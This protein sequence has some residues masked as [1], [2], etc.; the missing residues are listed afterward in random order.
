MQNNNNNN[1]FNLFINKSSFIK[2][3]FILN[4]WMVKFSFMIFSDIETLTNIFKQTSRKNNM[5]SI[6]PLI[7]DLSTMTN[8]PEWLWTLVLIWSLFWKGRAMWKAAHKNSPIWFVV[9]MVVTTVGILEILYIYLFSELKLD[10]LKSRDS[11]RKLSK[12]KKPFKQQKAFLD[13]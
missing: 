1:I 7:G 12:S 11:K 8:L 6:N 13:S 3:F 2:K 4:F 10:D 9:L 5:G